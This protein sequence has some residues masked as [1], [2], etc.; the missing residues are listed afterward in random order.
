VGGDKVL[1]TPS[2]VEETLRALSAK[3]YTSFYIRVG[4]TGECEHAWVQTRNIAGTQFA[5]R[6]LPARRVSVQDAIRAALA[7]LD[8][9]W[10][11]YVGGARED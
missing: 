2:E 10:S 6:V 7:E 5:I 1:P 4:E 11:A 9:Q 3:R 8:V